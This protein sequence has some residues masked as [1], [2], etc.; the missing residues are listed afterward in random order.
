MRD[1]LTIVA[2][3]VLGLLFVIA[4]LLDIGDNFII[5]MILIVGFIVIVVNIIWV[6]SKKDE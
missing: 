2:T 5:K 4:G 1:H 6:K 3:G